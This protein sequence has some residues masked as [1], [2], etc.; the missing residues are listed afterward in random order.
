MHK[1]QPIYEPWH[2]Q[3]LLDVARLK[4]VKAVEKVFQMEQL[5]FENSININIK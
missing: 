2:L 3:P 4:G 1:L 5:A